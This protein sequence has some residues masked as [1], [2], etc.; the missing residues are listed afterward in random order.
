[1]VMS[2][3]LLGGRE[4]GVRRVGV[5]FAVCIVVALAGFAAALVFAHGAAESQLRILPPIPSAS[6][7][8][9]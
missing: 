5:V 2:A 1:M 7:H 6:G 9:R 4:H 3:Y 8:P